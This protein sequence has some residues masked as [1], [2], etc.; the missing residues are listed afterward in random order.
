MAGIMVFLY[1]YSEGEGEARGAMEE[2]DAMQ[3]MAGAMATTNK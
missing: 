2:L 3:A 1:S